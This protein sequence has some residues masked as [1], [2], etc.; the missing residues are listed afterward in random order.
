STP[1]PGAPAAKTPRPRLGSDQDRRRFSLPDA[2]MEA[3]EK[4]KTALKTASRIKEKYTTGSYSPNGRRSSLKGQSPSDQRLESEKPQRPVPKPR[5]SLSTA[6]ARKSRDISLRSNLASATKERDSRPT[7]SP[8]KP[9]KR[10]SPGI[11]SAPPK[12]EQSYSTDL[13]RQSARQ[14]ELAPDSS[15]ME[16]M[17]MNAVE[18]PK[19]TVR[20]ASSDVK[21][22]L[23]SN[24]RSSSAA[25]MSSVQS[26][27]P[28]TKDK[29]T[30]SGHGIADQTT[31]INT[32]DV[33][34]RETMGESRRHQQRRESER[35][36]G[37][38]AAAALGRRASYSPVI[39]GHSDSGASTRAP[40][41]RSGSFSVRDA[42]T[43]SLSYKGITNLIELQKLLSQTS[44]SVERNNIRK[45][46]RHLR[47][48]PDY[49]QLKKAKAGSLQL[50]AQGFKPQKSSTVDRPDVVISAA[51][52][53]P[54]KAH[55]Q[56]DIVPRRSST[57][58]DV[59]ISTNQQ[60][61]DKGFTKRSAHSV[62]PNTDD[63]DVTS[64]STPDVTQRFHGTSNRTPPKSDQTLIN[65]QNISPD[66]DGLAKV[67]PNLIADSLHTNY[68]NTTKDVEVTKDVEGKKDEL[69]TNAPITKD[70]SANVL[71][72]VR[73]RLYSRS[74]NAERKTPDNLT[75]P[76][77][78]A[79]Q[80]SV[81]DAKTP[82]RGSTGGERYRQE[83]QQILAGLAP[84]LSLT[85]ETS[86]P[87]IQSSITPLLP[88]S[89]EASEKLGHTRVAN[90]ATFPTRPRESI[91]TKQHFISA[92]IVQQ[93]NQQVVGETESLHQL[94]EGDAT[95]S[96]REG[97]TRQDFIFSDINSALDKPTTPVTNHK[98]DNVSNDREKRLDDLTDLKTSESIKKSPEALVSS[99]ALGSA[100]P[101]HAGSTIRRTQ[102]LNAPI[103]RDLPGGMLKPSNGRM[104]HDY[105]MK[106]E[107]SEMGAQDVT[108][109]WSDSK[110]HSSLEIT[111][112]VSRPP[113]R[114]YD[115]LNSDHS[116]LKMPST[117][118]GVSET[119]PS[120]MSSDTDVT[121]ETLELPT[122]STL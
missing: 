92:D 15:R 107:T 116:T 69:T 13:A 74:S 55:G 119:F 2:D 36:S 35:G 39:S 113:E 44:D 64:K 31:L 6:D 89:F 40:A 100:D 68:F 19:S 109:H 98:I 76:A 52:T 11:K 59:I 18:Y 81:T 112:G 54:T 62:A 79:A 104:S 12:H 50:T 34:E 102:S 122:K 106:H 73:S 47:H 111:S 110:T 37:L 20:R 93:G 28:P 51:R 67:E 103:A 4:I 97:Q 9:A 38:T 117:F 99:L 101:G 23:L 24:R 25:V 43:V 22:Y 49:E 94:E 78:G 58:S 5:M 10:T 66:K 72:F 1:V 65:N 86:A 108:D 114:M 77:K 48:L 95:D 27:P 7:T 57:A 17:P 80:L 60:N 32:A 83:R 85:P 71:D 63:S 53:Q 121:A 21:D 105:A 33:P 120:S 30:T 90:D 16:A 26:R 8:P 91:K 70:E 14:L 87:L 29:A 115:T 61:H 88:S 75:S 56:G 46:I 96:Q 82:R 3:R 42:A 45:V 118:Q 84:R 41:G